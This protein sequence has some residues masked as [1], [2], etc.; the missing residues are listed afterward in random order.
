[1]YMGI[2][3][4]PDCI[5]M[6][7]DTKSMFPEVKINQSLP[8]CTQP[9]LCTLTKAVNQKSWALF[10]VTIVTIRQY[11][12]CCSVVLLEVNTMNDGM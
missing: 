5:R 7:C 8:R 9:V 1:M 6:P 11:A 4:K 10:R 3:N 2:L 12:F